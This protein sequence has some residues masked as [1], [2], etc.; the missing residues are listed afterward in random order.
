MIAIVTSGTA[1]VQANLIAFPA[2]AQANLR[3][4]MHQIGAS[5]TMRVVELLSGQVLHRRS[6]TLMGS[7]HAEQNESMT[8]IEELVGTAVP[9]GRFWE[10]GYSGEEAVRAYQRIQRK[11]RTKSGKRGKATGIADVRAHKRDVTVTARPFLS[12][13]LNDQR[14]LITYQLRKALGFAS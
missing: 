10:L 11:R 9:Y 12:R 4:V 5:L 3:R 2:K 6:G 13:A 14:T 1:Q 7:I 8:T